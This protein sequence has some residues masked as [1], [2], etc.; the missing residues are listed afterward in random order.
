MTRNNIEANYSSYN[1]PTRSQ[2]IEE[3]PIFLVILCCVLTLGCPQIKWRGRDNKTGKY[4]NEDT[5]N[6]FNGR[7]GLKSF[8]SL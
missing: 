5:N 6:R 2:F 7:L 8:H 4:T 3:K 1:V